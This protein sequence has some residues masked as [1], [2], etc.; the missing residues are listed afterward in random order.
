MSTLTVIFIVST[1]FEAAKRVTDRKIK[2][3]RH[4]SG[5]SEQIF[6][7]LNQNKTNLADQRLLTITLIAY[8][9]LWVCQI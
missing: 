4:I 9:I 3:K 1:M 5:R 6:D 2:R 7:R 8:W